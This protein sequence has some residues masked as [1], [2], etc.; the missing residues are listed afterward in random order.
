MKKL[1]LTASCALPLAAWGAPCLPVPE[2]I[3]LDSRYEEAMRSGDA[4]FLQQLLAD[5]YV[6]VHTLASAFDTKAV[7]LAKTRLAHLRQRRRR[8]QAAGGPDH[9]GLVQRSEMNPKSFR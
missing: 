3:A 1:S 2:L 5:D 7:V 9:E 6:W 4:A 8:L